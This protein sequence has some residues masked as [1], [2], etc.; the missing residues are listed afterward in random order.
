MVLIIYEYQNITGVKLVWFYFLASAV[1]VMVKIR[2]TMY[3]TPHTNIM[4]VQYEP[5]QKCKGD[6]GA[7]D[8]VSHVAFVVLISPMRCRYFR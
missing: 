2:N 3:M 1:N 4:I 7:L 5:K 8:S 6:I